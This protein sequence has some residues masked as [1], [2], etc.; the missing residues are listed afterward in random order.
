MLL[1]VLRY[2]NIFVR[3]NPLC[4]LIMRWP[5]QGCHPLPH[6]ARHAILANTC[7]NWVNVG[8]NT[9]QGSSDCCT[10][11]IKEELENHS[12]FTE[13]KGAIPWQEQ[14]TNNSHV[15]DRSL[16][17]RFG[18][19]R[20]VYKWSK[21]DRSVV[22][23]SSLS[24]VWVICVSFNIWVEEHESDHPDA[25]LHENTWLII[26]LSNTEVLYTVISAIR[27]PSLKQELWWI[28]SPYRRSPTLV[29]GPRPS[30]LV[31]GQIDKPVSARRPQSNVC[32]TTR[33]I[34]NCPGESVELPLEK[35]LLVTHLPPLCIK[36]GCWTVTVPL[37]MG[38]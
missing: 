1:K 27:F 7:R 33:V 28:L 32:T 16:W 15:R 20:T 25:D 38:P 29:P 9:G 3:E 13:Q 12:T 18:P 14:C 8:P 11:N 19:T 35:D 26:K 22:V 17:R 34:R 21:S 24:Y 36:G 23:S 5:A 6:K 37:E 4:V 30:L 2:I 31:A 10:T